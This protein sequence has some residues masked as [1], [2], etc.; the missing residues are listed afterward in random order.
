MKIIILILFF[1]LS[2]TYHQPLYILIPLLVTIYFYSLQHFKILN[3]KYNRLYL[4]FFI[5][6]LIF[7]I[8]QSISFLRIEWHSLKGLARYFSYSVFAIFV[9]KISNTEIKLLFKI[10]AILIIILFPFTFMMLD[11]SGGYKGIFRHSNHLG[12][13]LTIV[14]YFL[15]AYKPFSVLINYLVILILTGL[16]FYS[17]T[18]GAIVSFA[19]LIIYNFIISR[20]IPIKHK[21]FFIFGPLLMIIPISFQFS[22]KII[23]QINSLNY[24]DKNFILQ[25]VYTG[26]PGGYGSFIWRVVYWLQILFEFI[27]ESFFKIFF[28]IG[29][30][31]LTKGNMPY[32]IMYTD[33]HNDFLK[34]LVEFGVAGLI[35]FLN[36]IK[37]IFII[38][39]KNINILIL[40]TLPLM[41]D[42]A[43]VNFSFVLTLMLLIAYEYKN[44]YSERGN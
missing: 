17:R 32:R 21:L 20:N 9:Y 36:F 43:I 3:N 12:Y 22:E 44:L 7:F 19:L 31:A 24:L 14:I 37:N 6:I 35:L 29:I 13:V 16:L 42:N 28:G 11:E 10:I 1:L 5:I 15:F 26:N 27:K 40:I 2:A 4:S 33:P 39:N 8:I 25:R 34:V 38:L 30:D 23:E 18:S 41:F